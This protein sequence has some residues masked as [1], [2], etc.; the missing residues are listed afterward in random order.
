MT[1]ATELVTRAF[2][3]ADLAAGARLVEQAGW[4]QV[5]DDWRCF[6]QRGTAYAVEDAASRVVATAATLPYAGVAWISMVLVDLDWRRRGI[7]SGLIARCTRDLAAAGLVPVLDATPAGRTVYAGMDFLDVLGLQ[8]WQRGDRA[9]DA[10]ASPAAGLRTMRATDLDDV[11]ALDARAFGAPRAWLIESL[12][13]R[14]AGFAAVMECDGRIIGAVLGRP[15]RKA[16]QVGPIVATNEAAAVTLLRH[17][18][19]SIAGPVFIDALDHHAALAAAIERAGFTKQ[20]PY[21]RMAWRTDAIPGDPA[22][23][24]AAAGPELG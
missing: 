13:A 22:R 1:D 6:V 10:G 9:D 15:G 24:F 3:A 16:T 21:T 4:N 8:R 19:A 2:G 14:G 11:A 20:R 7:A 23:Y 17:A 18:A 5:D 12:A